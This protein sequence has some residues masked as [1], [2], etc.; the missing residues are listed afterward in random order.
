MRKIE[1]TTDRHSLF[2][3]SNKNGFKQH[4]THFNNNMVFSSPSSNFL[5]KA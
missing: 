2:V 4:T 1:L 5:F 3:V